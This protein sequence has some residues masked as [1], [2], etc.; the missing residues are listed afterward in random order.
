MFSQ[1]GI[2]DS[3]FRE[4]IRQGKKENLIKPK[5]E[6]L[7]LTIGRFDATSSVKVGALAGSIYDSNIINVKITG[8]NNVVIQGRNLV[9]GFA[10]LINNKET[11]SLV[12]LNANNIWISSSYKNITILE[13]DVVNS[14]GIIEGKTITSYAN[15]PALL[16]NYSY[17]GTIA[18]VLVG[19]NRLVE[20]KI[21]KQSILSGDPE[22]EEAYGDINAHN[23]GKI[24]NISNISASGG[25]VYAMMAGGLFGYIGHNTRVAKASYTVLGDETSGQRIIGYVYAG[26]I[27]AENYGIIER[28]F[29]QH[30]KTLQNTYDTNLANGNINPQGLSS[31]FTHNLNN[32]INVAIG[33]IAGFSDSSIILDSYVKI[34]V[35]NAY[36]KIAGGLVGLATRQNYF[37]HIFV[38][39][40]VFAK[41]VFGGVVGLYNQSG[42]NITPGNTTPLL[43]KPNKV[44]LYSNTNKQDNSIIDVINLTNAE[45]AAISLSSLRTLSGQSDVADYTIVTN[46]KLLLDYVVALNTWGP[47][48]KT[49]VVN[50]VREYYKRMNVEQ[51]GYYSNYNI[52]MQEVGN[53]IPTIAGINTSG[54]SPLELSRLDVIQNILTPSVFVGSLVGR[55]ALSNIVYGVDTIS[56]SDQRHL[57]L[58]AAINKA[59]VKSREVSLID[60]SNQIPT[61]ISTTFSSADTIVTDNTTTNNWPTEA[62][63]S[64][65]GDILGYANSVGT[66]IKLRG[67]IGK[68]EVGINYFTQWTMDA[69]SKTKLNQNS[70]STV[71]KLQNTGVL[72]EFIVGIYSNY[73]VI[74]NDNDFKTKLIYKRNTISQYFVLKPNQDN[75]ANG[76]TYDITEEGYS[77]YNNMFAFDFKG[78]LIGEEIE[79]GGNVIKPK[80]IFHLV[81]GRSSIFKNIT[82]GVLSNIDFEIVVDPGAN[83]YIDILNNGDIASI[84][85][86]L[87]A[88]DVYSSVI[89]NVN[90]TITG[91]NAVTFFRPRNGIQNFG[92]IFGSVDSS[93]V[94]N[95]SVSFKDQFGYDASNQA[96]F[97]NLTLNTGVLAAITSK[98]TFSKINIYGYDNDYLVKANTASANSNTVRV[99]GLIGYATVNTVLSNIN[100]DY[101]FEPQIVKTL[102]IKVES[103]RSTSNLI[104]GGL[105]AEL[106]DGN[107]TNVNYLGDIVV[108]SNGLLIVKTL[109]FGGLFGI[110]NSSDIANAQINS[111]VLN[112]SYNVHKDNDENLF[113]ITVNYNAL[114]GSNVGGIVGSMQ[115]TRIASQSIA[116]NGITNYIYTNNASNI[117]VT[118]SYNSS[119]T[120]S[121]SNIGGI[122][123]FVT[124]SRSQDDMYGLHNVLNTGNIEVIK[125]N[126]SK[127]TT[128][129]GGI[130]GLSNGIRINE[131]YSYG[132]IS[133][134]TNGKYSIGGV[135]GFI[136]RSNYHNTIIRTMVYGD[137][138]NR[139]TTVIQDATHSIGGIV[140]GSS[141]SLVTITD[142]MSLAR[143]NGINTALERDYNFVAGIGVGINDSMIQNVYYVF[144]FV[145]YFYQKG[146]VSYAS[147]EMLNK[148]D[149]LTDL[150][151][152]IVGKTEEE[153]KIVKTI[154]N[155]T[156][157]IKTSSYG[158]NSVIKLPWLVNM[159]ELN[160]IDANCGNK[161]YGQYN[162]LNPNEVTNANHNIVSNGYNILAQSLNNFSSVVTNFNGVLVGKIINNGAG[163]YSINVSSALNA[164]SFVNNNYGI[165]ANV[166]VKDTSNKVSNANSYFVNNN[167]KGAVLL[168]VVAYGAI[169]NGSTANTG[170]FGGLVY[171]N[172]GNILSSGSSFMFNGS[173]SKTVSNYGFGAIAVNN[174]AGG[175]IKDVY[176]TTNIINESAD[177]RFGGLV[178]NNQGRVFNSYYAGY[179]P[180]STINTSNPMIYGG[181]G[182]HANVYYD[183]NALNLSV[184]NNFGKVTA[185]LA[186]VDNHGQL[187]NPV[188]VNNLQNIN[189]G[190]ATLIRGVKI[191]TNISANVRTTIN[192]VS[193]VS[194]ASYDVDNIS[195][196]S[197]SGYY[198]I[199]NSAM[200]TNLNNVTSG[201]GYLIFKN[202][203]FSNYKATDTTKNDDKSKVNV[204]LADLSTRVFAGVGEFKEI[205]NI[206]ALTAG[207]L[208]QNISSNSRVFNLKFININVDSDKSVGILAQNISNS[209]LSNLHFDAFNVKGKNQVGVV[210]GTYNQTSES[211]Y[212]INNI[213]IGTNTTNKLTGS[214]EVGGL[215]GT[216]SVATRGNVTVSNVEVK[217]LDI[218]AAQA[219][220]GIIGSAN[221]LVVYKVN[222]N[223]ISFIRTN[224]ST[225][226]GGSFGSLV[227]SHII[228]VQARNISI[229]AVN[230]LSYVGGFI[231]NLTGSTIVNVTVQNINISTKQHNQFETIQYYY[232]KTLYW[233]GYRSSQ[234]VGWT[235]NIF[236]VNL[237]FGDG[238]AY[239][240]A[241]LGTIIGFSSINNIGSYFVEGDNN[242][243]INGEL[244]AYSMNVRKYYS[245]FLNNTA[246]VKYD[247]NRVRYNNISISSNVGGSSSKAV[248]FTGDSDFELVSK[249]TQ[250]PTLSQD[251]F[252]ITDWS[253][254]YY[255][256]VIVPNISFFQ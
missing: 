41:N 247:I 107:V 98:T 244:Y 4:F 44:I 86:G 21:I 93:S 22:A 255:H 38:Y 12:G 114:S 57:L 231:G 43:G 164:R 92:V 251:V 198:G 210:A 32:A 195:Y 119:T 240:F 40:N 185:T 165:I 124:N 9:G 232:G 205:R 180:S 248:W 45:M 50:N 189:Y 76:Y 181:N 61:V 141:S 201:N 143:I 214:V 249:F 216:A 78:I 219:A 163:F 131:T 90:I 120:T 68:D 67:I 34:N 196:Y 118:A 188:F 174:N 116:I 246:N 182:S 161:L 59:I 47:N 151:N 167:Q 237:Y 223:T 186:N 145:P 84:N 54:L 132:D 239:D 234:S 193:D 256:G 157:L 194:M 136:A 56:G 17:A 221:N 31:V 55:I 11:Y 29:V 135:I 128:Y 175:I 140:G 39:G 101:L 88:R 241:Y 184:N 20:D 211:N 69:M 166:G 62:S 104:V 66:Q 111:Y 30:E 187:L 113:N 8:A 28:S 126:P 74:E 72:P 225:R 148:F 230:H 170:S 27:V 73:N 152:I 243:S 197:S 48:A 209:S 1:V 79:V 103:I 156:G 13:S 146:A 46:N 191:Y 36:S 14:S 16:T 242:I 204:L 53:Q 169:Q 142:S 23:R 106:I 95:L 162:K 153:S 138:T 65:H 159:Y 2:S 26:G 217:M 99:G 183:H 77:V 233:W 110:V 207:Y 58:E 94:F 253:F 52:I 229:N 70:S 100:T 7:N 137:I 15:N 97:N 129:V 203:D 227:T 144:E 42:T 25:S 75:A 147:L 112:N 82:S 178:V 37:S 71:W 228:D 192:T 109:N 89:S 208:F 168:N 83:D 177:I 123:G 213:Y 154:F 202:I 33:G 245:G 35:A 226:T 130:V 24:G 108:G 139:E 171:N 5:I 87:F 49:A 173:L 238:F 51:S 63:P 117:N 80:I 133:V 220:G 199:Y 60:E 3:Q 158:S 172:S 121:N 250:A 222:S 81:P 176:S 206:K 160:V 105:V 18:G 122:V 218:D 96:A 150:N 149:Y 215:F 10:G 127:V 190:Y 224:G 155:I 115:E 235:N 85:A 125:T 252:L 6:N 212:Y 19:N 236:S 64:V 91:P 134:N 254:P 102:Q 179:V 200:L